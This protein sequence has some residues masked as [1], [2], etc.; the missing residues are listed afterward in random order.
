MKFKNPPTYMF[1][2]N[3]LI[4]LKKNLNYRISP[5]GKKSSLWTEGLQD[6]VIRV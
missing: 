4:A 1:K 6:N 3:S 5:E 2:Q